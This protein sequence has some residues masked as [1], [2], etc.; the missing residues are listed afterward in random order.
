MSDQNSQNESGPEATR[1]ERIEKKLERYRFF[2]K[3]S[4]GQKW[5][6]HKEKL[7]ATKQGRLV[8]KGLGALVPIG[9]II[10]IALIRNFGGDFLRPADYNLTEEQVQEGYSRTWGESRNSGKDDIYF[11]FYEDDEYSLPSCD[12]KFDWCVFAIPLH[13]N[14]LEI[15]MDFQTSET[16]SGTP[17]I[18]AFRTRVSSENGVPFFLGQ[19]VTLGVESQDPDSLYGEVKSIICRRS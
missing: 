14:C 7:R 16:D 6:A 1:R 13:K 11:R 15:Q 10:L 12:T 18:E 3:S 2:R 17:T 4:L 5:E 8:L 19:R 9:G